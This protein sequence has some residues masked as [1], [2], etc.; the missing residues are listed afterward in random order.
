[1]TMT[2]QDNPRSQSIDKLYGKKPR[3][4]IQTQDEFPPVTRQPEM[5][6]PGMK[7]EQ[8]FKQQFDYNEPPTMQGAPGVGDM[9][10]PPSPQ[11]LQEHGEAAQMTD[12]DLLSQVQKQMT[13]PSITGDKAKD[14][15]ALEAMTDPK[16][17]QDWQ[18]QL[19]DFYGMGDSPDD[20]QPSLN[21]FPP[22]VEEFTKKFGR[23]PATD[24]EMD[25]YYGGGGDPEPMDK[26]L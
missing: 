5:Q 20:R 15:Q 22:T 26:R 16:E 24:S 18:D 13:Q 11:M 2:Y 4:D 12:E 9:P 21:G 3:R 23:E 19:D 10:I 17:R 25:F 1:M 7:N 6:F 14:Y 8:D